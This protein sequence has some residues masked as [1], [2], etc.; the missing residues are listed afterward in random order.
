MFNP[1]FADFSKIG[2]KRTPFGP[3]SRRLH[4]FLSI[5]KKK[6]TTMAHEEINLPHTP[7]NTPN[8]LPARGEEISRSNPGL[9]RTSSDIAP[10]PI[11]PTP[12][13]APSNSPPSPADYGYCWF[14]RVDSFGRRM[15]QW[16]APL[17]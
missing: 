3:I 16:D 9:F 14:I 15:E 8:H 10:W 13:P 1:K 4:F 5:F 6:G 17:G 7:M 11:S 12:K 2:P